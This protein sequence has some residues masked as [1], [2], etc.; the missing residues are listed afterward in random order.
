MAIHLIDAVHAIIDRVREETGKGV[1]FI[2]KNDLTTFA[3]LKMARRNMPSHVVFYK[4]THDEIINHLVA[5]ECGHVLRMFAVPEEKRLVPYSDDGLK[6][7]ALGQIEGEITALS[8]VLP[9]EQLAGVV[10]LWYTGIIRQVTNH[11]PD[12][13]IEKWLY[14]E[15]PSLRPYQSKSIEKQLGESLAGLGDSVK[16]ITP[17][18]IMEASNIMNYAFFRLLGMHL[19]TNF[20]RPYNNTPYVN[21][22]KELAA[23]TEKEYVNTYEGDILM[24]D[25][26]AKLLRLADWFKWRDFEDVPQGYT[27]SVS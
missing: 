14:D 15:Y 23:V 24:A 9:F 4:G 5:H 22:G 17:R 18:T 20:I 6:L 16:Q 3:A 11:P 12:I 10:N 21:R 13:M 8:K 19:R 1:E 25:R 7:K 26:W 27:D 2:E